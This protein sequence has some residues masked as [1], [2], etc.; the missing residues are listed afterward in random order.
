[1]GIMT[2]KPFRVCHI[3]RPGEGNCEW[4]IY[5]IEEIQKLINKHSTKEQKQDEELLEFEF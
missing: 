1:M 4:K 2:R 5:N 3:V